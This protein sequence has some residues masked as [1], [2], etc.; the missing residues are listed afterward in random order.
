MINA[1]DSGHLTKEEVTFIEAIGKR[2][3]DLDL[4]YSE[5]FQPLLL[6]NPDA[7]VG[8]YEVLTDSGEA[9]LVRKGS[10]FNKLKLNG[11]SVRYDIEEC[12]IEYAI[13]KADIRLA[14]KFGRPLNLEYVERAKRATD[15]KINA[16]CYRG[17]TEFGEFPGVLELVGLTSYSGTALNTASLNIVNEVVNAFN[18]IPQK[19][20]RRSYTLVVADR[21]W[22]VFTKIV[23]NASNA[24]IMTLIMQSIPNLKIVNEADLTAGLDLAGG[25]TIAAGTALFIPNDRELTRLPIAKAVRSVIDSNSQSNE[26]L[27]ELKG[28]VEARM[29]PVEVPFPTAVVKVTGW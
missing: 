20:R 6:Q 15:E 22:K 16:L 27:K 4:T 10:R 17:D 9:N 13:R 18:S 19:F 24:N 29:G 12:G 7:E 3:P 8:K 25:G 26:F 5:V 2:S 23:D 28:R 21:E 14:R 1:Q 11:S